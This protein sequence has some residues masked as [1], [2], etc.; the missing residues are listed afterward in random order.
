M[1]RTKKICW[2]WGNKLHPE[3][4]INYLT[5]KGGNNTQRYTGDDVAAIYFIGRSGEIEKT[6]NIELI[7]IIQQTQCDEDNS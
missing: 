2:R 3:S 6:N 1:S 5:K 7:W 4:V